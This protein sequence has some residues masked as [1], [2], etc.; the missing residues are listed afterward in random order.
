MEET[1]IYGLE[2]SMSS[3]SESRSAEAMHGYY[4]I[5]D[6]II[7]TRSSDNYG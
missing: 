2:T 7:C 3:T 6:N 5:R 4:C 1:T